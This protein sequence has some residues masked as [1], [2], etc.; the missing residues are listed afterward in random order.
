MYY[1]ITK[2]ESI[3]KKQLLV[4]LAVC[5]STQ[6]SARFEPTTSYHRSDTTQAHYPHHDTSDFGFHDTTHRPARA[7][8]Q[9]SRS[10]FAKIGE[11]SVNYLYHIV[12]TMFGAQAQFKWYTR[13]NKVTDRKISD[14]IAHWHKLTP[15]IQDAILV[16]IDADKRFGE[17]YRKNF[18]DT[19]AVRTATK[20]DFTRVPHI[21]KFG[22]RLMYFRI[23]ATGSI[24]LGTSIKDVYLAEERAAGRTTKFFMKRWNSLKWPEYKPVQDIIN[25]IMDLDETVTEELR[26]DTSITG[27]EKEQKFHAGQGHYQG[28]SH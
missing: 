10:D 13:H 22:T 17:S 23:Q 5:A 6:L 15:K 25:A 2:G 27:R 8:Q 24:G 11:H 7:L 3:M 14:I 16:L 12:R 21:S 28:N 18:P 9:P 1:D 20:P 4:L 26:K 19:D